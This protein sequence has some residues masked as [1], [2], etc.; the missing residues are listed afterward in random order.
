[1]TK[2]QIEYILT[3][4]AEND[5]RSIKIHYAGNFNVEGTYAVL[6]NDLLIVHIQGAER[7]HG[8]TMYIDISKIESITVK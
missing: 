2:V 8:S 1:M 3:Q 7:Y 5:Y 4:I 6:I